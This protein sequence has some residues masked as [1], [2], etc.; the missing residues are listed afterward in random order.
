MIVGAVKNTICEKCGTHQR[1]FVDIK[2]FYED[3][4]KCHCGGILYE[5]NYEKAKSKKWKNL[6]IDRTLGYYDN[7]LGAYI[8]S[9]SDRRRVCKEKGFID[10]KPGEWTQI[11]SK[12]KSEKQELSEYKQIVKESAYKANIGL[13]G[14][15]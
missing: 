15:S 11:K 13:S 6:L 8:G 12:A 4:I 2:D 1:K 14:V 3:K 10:C 7:Q 9:T 5:Q